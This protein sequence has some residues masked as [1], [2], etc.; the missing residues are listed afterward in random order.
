MTK[1]L[2]QLRTVMIITL[3]LEV[4]VIVGLYLIMDKSFLLMLGIYAFIKNVIILLCI[5]YLSYQIEE[6][7]ISVT[8]ALNSDAKNAFLFG[9]IGLIQYDENRNI[10]WTSDLFKA[11]DINIIGAKLLEWQPHLVS[12]FDDEDIKVIDIK[13][14][15]YEAYNSQESKLIYLKDV[16]QF[17]TLQ[18]DYADS[19]VA[20]AY[21]TIDN[22]EETLENAD[23][24]KMALIQSRSRQVI[25]D[26]AYSNGIII[27]RYKSGGYL[28]F[29]NERTYRKQVEN[30]F[31]ILDT[32]KHMSDELDEVMTLSIGIGRSSRVLRELDEMA[33][34]ALN[35]TYSRGGDQVAVKSGGEEKVVYFGGNT[36]IYEKS[37]KVR[38]RVIAQSLAGLIKRADRI[39]IMGHKNSDLDS[40]GASLGVAKIATAYGKKTNIIVDFDS[41]EEKTKQVALTVR[42]DARYAGMIISVN[43]ALDL[44]T[45][46]TLLVVVDNHKPKLALAPILL[47][48]V[49]NK[50]I[51]DHH[52]RGEEFIE[53]PVLTYLEPA[54]SSTVELLVELC[55]YQNVNLDFNEL[56]ATVMYAGMLVDTNYFKQRVGVRTFQSAAVLKDW[57]ANVTQAYEFLEDSYESTLNKISLT[58]NAYRFNDNI[59]IRVGDFN[60]EYSREMLAKSSNAL[61]EISHIKAAFTIGR[62]D[63]NMVAVSARSSKGINVQVIMENI[64]GGGHF[65]MAAAQ[66]EDKSIKEVQ[67]LLEEAISHYLEDRG[68]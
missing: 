32:F 44:I 50:V 43:E 20:M 13:G 65:S 40:F 63:K 38:A 16:T 55:E 39:L 18:Q 1:K 14:R 21:I 59:L 67:E 49:K 45:K 52:R 9:G 10:T 37:S 12:L 47:E 68:E 4:I 5:L 48:R 8:D 46:N 56:D 6:N 28:A 64:G 60:Q 30:K 7:A 33:M 58:A 41:I 27:R 51:I 61:L 62:V 36:D 29:F 54:A 22:Y 35:L 19:Q 24:P 66:F 53:S 2:I 42:N 34:A 11:L 23:E 57:Q 15:K 17:L 3:I 26:W 25:V 31:A